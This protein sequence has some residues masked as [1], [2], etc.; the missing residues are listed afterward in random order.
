M[1]K[2]IELY[3]FFLKNEKNYSN[4]TIVS[5]RN[6]LIQFFNYLKLYRIL[7]DDKIEYVDRSVMRKYI[8]Y[9]KKSDYSARS[10][11]R[12]IS[13]VRS[14][15][16]FCLR[17]GII[18]VNPT[19]NLITPK[20]NKKLPYFLYLQEVNKLIETPLKNT[21]FGIRDRAILE[22]LYGTGIRVGELVNLNICNIDL[23]EKTIIVFGKGSKERILPLGNP[24]IRA[25]QEYLTSR[26][27]FEKKIFVNKNDLEALFL[28]RLGG[29]L[30][31][32]SIRR[33]IIKYMKMAGLNKK[34][35]PHVLRHSFATHLL[36]GG[37]DL[38]SVQE[39]LGHKSLST[40]QIYT[41]ITKER[42]KTIYKKSHPRA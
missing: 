22:L 5:Y 23:Y 6:D 24:S 18:K 29:R 8:V 33:I 36:E 9:L 3:A 35:S 26:N 16:K 1:K 39:L 15:F 37:A 10:I 21:I 19:I 28:N 30:T 11:S 20:I 7:K 4:Y 34:I 17:E 12:K 41:H 25:I 14:F 40:T 38:R 2:Y 13:T 31:T 32:R 42:L 27:L